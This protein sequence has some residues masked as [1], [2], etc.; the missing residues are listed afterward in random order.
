MSCF[1]FC[2]CPL[3][4]L[5]INPFF[6]LT[7]FLAFREVSAHGYP[8]FESTTQNMAEFASK[9]EGIDRRFRGMFF[10]RA[11][12]HGI[13]IHT[14]GHKPRIRF[15]LSSTCPTGIAQTCIWLVMLWNTLLPIRGVS[16]GIY[17]SNKVPREGFGLDRWK[18]GIRFIGEPRFPSGS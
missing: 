14:P 1:L 3:W 5:S 8:L 6:H 16:A 17:T 9:L 12:F 7:V 4:S 18:F 2:S 10:Q 11:V 15:R 13:V